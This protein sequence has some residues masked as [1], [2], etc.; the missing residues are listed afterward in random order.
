MKSSALSFALVAALLVSLGGKLLT[1]R[2]SPADDQSLF[3]ARATA[4]L[5][6]SGYATKV[7]MRKVGILVLGRKAGCRAMIGNY[8]PYGTF[9]NDF[10]DLAGPVG[11]LRFAWRG[12]LYDSAP[13]LMPLTLFYLRR[14]A[15]RIGFEPRRLPIAAIAVS[16][17]CGVPDPAGLASLPA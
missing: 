10:A 8:T 14:E 15:L 2:Q 16:P 7:E 11:P 1:N 3:A 6:S 13:K 5:R 9:A 12:S 4:L 17:G